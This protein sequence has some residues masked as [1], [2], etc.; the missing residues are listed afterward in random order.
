MFRVDGV[1]DRSPIEPKSGS[2]RRAER[3]AQTGNE[4][5]DPTIRSRDSRAFFET[6]ERK[7]DP[8]IGEQKRRK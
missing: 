2:H 3:L 8:V 1:P 6:P 7:N 5:I 4:R